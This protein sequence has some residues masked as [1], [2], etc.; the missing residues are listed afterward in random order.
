MPYVWTNP[1]DPSNVI[2]YMPTSKEYRKYWLAD[3]RKM[4]GDVNPFAE[5]WTIETGLEECF[6]QL[7]AHYDH[8]RNE[9]VFNAGLAHL[10]LAVLATMKSEIGAY[11]KIDIENEVPQSKGKPKHDKAQWRKWRSQARKKR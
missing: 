8:D 5:H 11:G 10:R 1:N 9:G 6:R 7:A 2:M 3:A 4:V